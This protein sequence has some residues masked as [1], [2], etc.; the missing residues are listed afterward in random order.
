MNPEHI[1]KDN[2]Q[3]ILSGIPTVV[4]KKTSISALQE[5][6]VAFQVGIPYYEFI[7]L[8]SNDHKT[9]KVC[10]TLANLGLEGTVI[11]VITYCCLPLIL[12]NLT[13]IIK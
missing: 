1:C 4:S 2:E 8:S 12:I 10:L 7:G 13:H 11:L 9:F 6:C 5:L 3:D